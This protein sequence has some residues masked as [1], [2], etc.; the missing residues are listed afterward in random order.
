[1][2]IYT[3]KNSPLKRGGEIIPIGGS[4]E[5][6]DKETIGL[7]KF[8]DLALDQSG[9]KSAPLNVA[10]TVQLVMAAET[11]EALAILT[12]GETRKGVLDAIAKRQTELA[13]Q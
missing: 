5:L 9:Q 6:T 7:E 10:Q 2:P 1:M 3:V 13:P 4:V 11:L 8:L 12:E